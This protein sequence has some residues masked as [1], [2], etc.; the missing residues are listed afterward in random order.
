MDDDEVLDF[1]TTVPVD[2]HSKTQTLPKSYKTRVKSKDFESNNKPTTKSNLTKTGSVNLVLSANSFVSNNSSNVAKSAPK[3]KQLNNTTVIRPVLTVQE[4]L[5]QDSPSLPPQA[6]VY[7]NLLEGDSV[8]EDSLIQKNT[9]EE[10]WS[11]INS[12]DSKNLQELQN[13]EFLDNSDSGT[14]GNNI[15]ES[16]EVSSVSTLSTIQSC[17]VTPLAT[18]TVGLS[19]HATPNSSFST[20]DKRRNSFK[21]SQMKA[22]HSFDL[23]KLLD[24]FEQLEREFNWDN[25]T[26]IRPPSAFSS[27]VDVDESNQ[28]TME[29]NQEPADQ[30]ANLDT[31]EAPENSSKR[32]TMQQNIEK[33]LR[34]MEA[35]SYQTLDRR[36]RRDLFK[37]AEAFR[38]QRGPPAQPP[39]PHLTPTPPPLLP[40]TVTART[41]EINKNFTQEGKTIISTIQMRNKGLCTEL[42]RAV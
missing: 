42:A 35:G 18:P 30:A 8:D 22:Q 25:V 17:H 9:G 41:P 32:C 15:E 29:V 1:H 4:K 26:C 37:K 12:E 28:E 21:R 36:S 31:G 20:H 38:A 5:A 3:S 10:S 2:D 24:P 39:P 33:S 11:T 16:D 34:L 13:L 40:S 6:E 14:T 7:V 23:A 19:K 27:L